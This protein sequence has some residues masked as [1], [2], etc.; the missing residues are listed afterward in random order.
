MH[1]GEKT[2]FVIFESINQTNILKTVG[3]TSKRKYDWD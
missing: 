1:F 2:A 3:I